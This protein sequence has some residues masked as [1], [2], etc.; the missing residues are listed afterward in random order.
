MA[1]SKKRVTVFMSLSRNGRIDYQIDWN[2][3]KEYCPRISV[4]GF[5]D[6][7]SADD[8]KNW[9]SWQFSQSVA[10]LDFDGQMIPEI[11]YVIIFLNGYYYNGRDSYGGSSWYAHDAFIS[12]ENA[13]KHIEGSDTRWERFWVV[14]IRRL[15]Q[16]AEALLG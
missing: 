4:C 16:N 1:E 9:P 5:L 7:D 15:P 8:K 11:M 3:E 13:E 2:K 6:P 12:K 10:V 14:P